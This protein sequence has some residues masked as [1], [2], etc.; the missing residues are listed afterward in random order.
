[1][2]GNGDFHFVFNKKLLYLWSCVDDVLVDD[3][4]KCLSVD[5]G[6]FDSLFL[7][8]LRGAYQYEKTR[9]AKFCGR[10]GRFSPN[11]KCEI[12]RSFSPILETFCVSDPMISTKLHSE[13]HVKYG[14]NRNEFSKFL[15]NH[16]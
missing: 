14:C 4:K 7:A 3:D 12:F 16:Q 15:H 6:W 13:D 5:F 2:C 1:M 8:L 11:A 9:G 10:F